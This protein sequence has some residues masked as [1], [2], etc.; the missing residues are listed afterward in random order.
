MD[1]RARLRVLPALGSIPAI[2][3]KSFSWGFT[4][5]NSDSSAFPADLWWPAVSGAADMA[6]RAWAQSRSPG[7]SVLPWGL[8]Q[9]HPQ[10]SV[11]G[12][13]V[14]VLC[15]RSLFKNEILQPR[16]E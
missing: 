3:E 14:P 1:P 8:T 16:A 13:E 6:G 15:V 10:G 5:V 9:T 7:A 2:L 4:G 12:P 11:G